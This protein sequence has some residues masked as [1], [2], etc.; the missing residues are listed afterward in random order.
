MKDDLD[1]IRWLDPDRFPK[2]MAMV[3]TLALSS[4]APPPAKRFRVKIEKRAQ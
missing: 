1:L 4:A 2:G 3:T